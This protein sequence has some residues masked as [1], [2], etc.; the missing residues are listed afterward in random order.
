[1]K[2]FEIFGDIIAGDGDRWAAAE[3]APAQ[4]AAF[5][6]EANGEAVAFN[7][8]SNGGD[9]TAG[10]AIANMI[11]AYG[12]ETVCNVLGVAASVSSVIACACDRLAMGEGAFLMIHNPWIV[13]AGG[14]EELRKDAETLDKLKAAIMGF[15][16]SKCDPEKVDLAKLMDEETWLSRDEA[17]A[18][19]FA[20]EDYSGGLKAAA[21]LTRRAYA[22]A[23]EAAKALVQV[24]EKP[25]TDA[26]EAA[27]TT[28]TDAAQAGAEAT[29]A[30]EKPAE[31]KAA[32]NWEA[33]FKGLSKKYNGLKA[34]LDEAESRH[35]SEL[36][37]MTAE[38]DNFK[39]QLDQSAKDLAAANAKV[40]ALSAKVEEGD[41]ALHAA[42]SDLAA[43][44]D[45]L[46]KAED[47]AKRLESTRDLLTA[48]VLTPPATSETY[49]AKMTA[50]K[51]AKEREELRAMKRA[52]KIK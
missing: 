9:A 12:G 43:A 2:T 25:A 39:S 3:V 31:D 47:K 21:C 11:K 19:G 10:I 20:V 32:D 16:A 45:S 35:A 18:L 7:V 5:L 17:K 48:G 15:Y 50:A 27:D 46:A 33:R 51:G 8:N 4:V 29:Q 38:R 13:T 41:K 52:G 28:A 22:K 42:Q 36:V 30:D 14:A 49:A 24:E 23:P 40:S 26:A 37:A 44:R 1:M 34:Q 6:K